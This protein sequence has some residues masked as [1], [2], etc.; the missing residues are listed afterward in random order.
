MKQVSSARQ[1]TASTAAPK[2]KNRTSRRVDTR[3]SNHSRPLSSWPLPSSSRSS[4]QTTPWMGAGSLRFYSCLSPLAS[5]SPRLLLWHSNSPPFLIR[6]PNKTLRNN[7]L[8]STLCRPSIATNKAKHYVS[9]K[10]HTFSAL[11]SLTAQPNWL[12]SP[13]LAR[14]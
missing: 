9:S 13:P 2:K 3:Q 5:F 10:K 12:V 1:S 14:V 6:Q 8:S 4:L 7:L 11:S